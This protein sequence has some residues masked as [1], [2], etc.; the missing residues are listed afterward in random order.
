MFN[1]L[2]TNG[3]ELNHNGYINSFY[4]ICMNCK[5]IDDL[6]AINFCDGTYIGP[7]SSFDISTN[8]VLKIIGNSGINMVIN[9]KGDVGIGTDTP[10][11][12]LDISGN[13]I[14]NK[15]YVK[16]AIVY[17][18]NNISM[19][20]I[21]SIV[22]RANNICSVIGIRETLATNLGN[23]NKVH[24]VG[25]LDATIATFGTGPAI[26]LYGTINTITGNATWDSTLSGG[27]ISVGADYANGG[28]I[29]VERTGGALTG[30]DVTLI[31]TRHI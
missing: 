17:E 23:G 18:N 3:F 16:D 9:E 28:S 2:L 7:G 15:V 27:N 24:I 6:S 30:I 26:N 29:W 31:I 20:Q 11:Q 25:G 21:E 19:G 5:T 10:T 14:S 4:D 13:T 22:V 12:R 1:G 8:Q